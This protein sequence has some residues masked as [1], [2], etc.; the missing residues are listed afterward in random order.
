M[1]SSFTQPSSYSPFSSYRSKQEPRGRRT[2]MIHRL[3][4]KTAR[5]PLTVWCFPL[6]LTYMR[7]NNISL[8]LKNPWLRAGPS[9]HS[10]IQ[11]LCWW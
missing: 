7:F 2:V 1:Y 11:I 6:N 5:A 10:E 8:V 4:T 3:S 9:S